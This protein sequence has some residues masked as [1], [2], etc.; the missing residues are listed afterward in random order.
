M[1]Y[2]DVEYVIMSRLRELPQMQADE[3]V[4]IP[5]VYAYNQASHTLVME[6][7]GTTETTKDLKSFLQTIDTRYSSKQEAVSACQDLG[8][9]IGAFLSALHSVPVEELTDASHGEVKLTSEH[10]NIAR[11]I[12]ADALYGRIRQTLESFAYSEETT[13]QADEIAN[14]ATDEIKNANEVFTHGDYWTGNLLVRQK[15]GQ[16]DLELNMMDWEMSKPGTPAYDVGQFIAETYC[17]YKYAKNDMQK[18][19]SKA[20][21]GAF[22]Q[23]YAEKVREA[24]KEIDMDGVAVRVGAHLIVWTPVTGWTEDVDA[25]EEVVKEGVDMLIKGSKSEIDYLKDSVVLGALFK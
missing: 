2:Q 22:E 7:L 21:L 1:P 10:F 16:D 12:S 8:N 20:L 6:D 14:K 24:G 9:A 18:E 15:L 3:L 25:L 5:E 11:D 4:R 17:L 23:K 13:A 19:C